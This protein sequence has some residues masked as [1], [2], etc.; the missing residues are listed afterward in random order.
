[1]IHIS[2]GPMTIYVIWVGAMDKAGMNVFGCM[3]KNG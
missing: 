2:H 3:I 1:M